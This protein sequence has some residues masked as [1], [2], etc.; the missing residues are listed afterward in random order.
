M[1][2]AK[3][4]I[5]PPDTELEKLKK[6]YEE[7]VLEMTEEVQKMDSKVKEMTE[8]LRKINSVDYLNVSVAT[9]TDL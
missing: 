5:P 3:E 7:A 8:K 2:E 9:V 6:E 4:I 1:E